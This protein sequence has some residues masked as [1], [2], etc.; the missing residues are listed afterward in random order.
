[1]QNFNLKG[2][3][4][5]ENF[6]L[7]YK[8]FNMTE[9]EA[10]FYIQLSYIS[11]QGEIELIS[12]VFSEKLEISEA[13]FFRK[14]DLLYSK[15]FISINKK[16][17]IIF[18]VTSNSNYFSL[19]ELLLFVEKS[20]NRVMSSKEID[21][22][23]TW[24]NNKFTKREIKEAFSISNNIHYVNGIL[25]NIPIKNDQELDEEDILNY[26]WLNK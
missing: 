22:I 16:N 10:L 4:I 6:I 21:I 2:I 13:E 9:E 15:K 11:N 8:K 18:L 14:M 26:D 7:N 5:D 19:K 20:I 3:F 1:M 12:K 25:N 23:Y 24:I 17:Q